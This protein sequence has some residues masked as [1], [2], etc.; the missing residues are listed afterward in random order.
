MAKTKIELFEEKLIEEG[1]TDDRLQEYEKL[2]K[3]SGN[4]WSR[5][6]HCYLTAYDF[7]VER[8]NDSVRLIEFGINK[9]GSEQGY[10]IPAYEM[11]G[12]IY[13]R[14]GYYQKAYDIYVSIFPN[15]GGFK[16]S[17]PWCLLDMKMH[18]DNFKYSEEM[19]QYYELCLAESDF[20][21]AFLQHRF[22]LTLADY[23]IAD[24]H[25][26]PDEKSNAYDAICEMIEP[27]YR[28]A[29]YECL[30]KHKYDEKLKITKECRAFL[31]CIK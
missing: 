31:A 28:G 12:T 5:I 6:Q 2:L 9:Y 11:L 16:G 24:Y 27:G 30:R 18:V 29:L 15:I 23:I 8:M 4:D 3:R 13:E 17:F 10:T 19:K 22:V 26:N 20:S 21:K 7:P 1:L 14:S 25:N